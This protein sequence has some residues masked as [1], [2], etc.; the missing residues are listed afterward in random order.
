VDTSV[1]RNFWVL[2]CFGDPA[3]S[4]CTEYFSLFSLHGR[5]GKPDEA[6]LGWLPEWKQV[7]MCI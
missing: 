1:D 5:R 6:F 7:C 4:I 3:L 2:R